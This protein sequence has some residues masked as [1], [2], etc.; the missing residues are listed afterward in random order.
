MIMEKLILKHLNIHSMP[1][2]TSLLPNEF[3]ASLML[4]LT[5]GLVQVR[6]LLFRRGG[7][8]VGRLV[9]V[10]LAVGCGGRCW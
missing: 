7:K 2:M 10:G 4:K 6:G 1:P 8:E 3:M 9:D 5:G